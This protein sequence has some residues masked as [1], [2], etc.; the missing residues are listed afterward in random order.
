MARVVKRVQ[1]TSIKLCLGMAALLM[2]VM[3]D[4][5]WTRMV[6]ARDVRITVILI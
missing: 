3:K 6:S 1:I 5:D 4:Q 2:N